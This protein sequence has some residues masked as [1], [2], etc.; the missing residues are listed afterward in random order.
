LAQHEGDAQPSITEKPF[1]N[2]KLETNKTQSYQR[3][4]KWN[5]IKR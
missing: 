3:T 1:E 2:Y 5:F 4:S